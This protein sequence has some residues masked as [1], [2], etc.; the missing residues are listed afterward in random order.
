M[1]HEMRARMPHWEFVLW[2]RYHAI[3]NAEQQVADDLAR[4]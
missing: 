3:L 4:G 1:V 2:S